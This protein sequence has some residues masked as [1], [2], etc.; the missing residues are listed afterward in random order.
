SFVVRRP[1]PVALVGLAIVG[2]ILSYGVQLNPSEAQAKDL[3]GG[4][5]AIDGRAALVAAGVS[6]GVYK[7]FE[8]L[9]EGNVT[10]VALERIASR[11]GSTPGVEGATAPPQ[12][13][14]PDVALIEAIPSHDGAA[15]SVRPVISS[16]QHDVLPALADE[17]GLR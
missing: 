4:G 5:N 3:P 16:L 7:P 14:K 13:R 11:V 8:I 17:T 1:L 9:V 12:W 2:V 10:P 15:K 6:A